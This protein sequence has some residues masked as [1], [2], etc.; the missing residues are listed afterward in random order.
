MYSPPV[1]RNVRL[2]HM[3]YGPTSH[4]IVLLFSCHQGVGARRYNSYDKHVRVFRV[5]KKDAD[6][7]VSL[8]GVLV[9]QLTFNLRGPRNILHNNY[10]H[11]ILRSNFGEDTQV[12]MQANN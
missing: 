12:T 2:I 3:K 1:C 5:F 11:N 4:E 9:F 8:A 10:S 7:T 6:I